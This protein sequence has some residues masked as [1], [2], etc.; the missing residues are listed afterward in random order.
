MTRRDYFAEGDFGWNLS[1][2]CRDDGTLESYEEFLESM[3]AFIA[4][5]RNLGGDEA[6]AAAV[7]AISR[8]PAWQGRAAN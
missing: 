1:R 7:I 3:T 8:L 5:T 2:D 4:R 6:R